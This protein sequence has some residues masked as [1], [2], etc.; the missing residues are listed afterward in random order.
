[1]SRVART[2]GPLVARAAVLALLALAAALAGCQSA[3]TVRAPPAATTAS[4]ATTPPGGPAPTGL[5]PEPGAALLHVDTAASRI[6]MRLAAAGALAALGHSHVV[7]AQGLA[8]E[9]LLPPEPAGTRFELSFPVAQLRVDDPADRAAAGGEFAAPIPDT[10]RAGTREHM[11]G[12]G[13]LDA[14]HFARIVLRGQS[15]RVLR[16]DAAAGEGELALVIELLGR[17]V[18]LTAPV[19]WQ[20]TA[21]GL[22]VQGELRLLQSALGIQPYSVGGGALRVADEVGVRYTLLAR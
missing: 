2:A 21:H 19:R 1:L 3:P 14:T 13:Q 16:G 11:L 8:G 12:P 18:P 17:S 4:P 7:V 22:E 5:L 9:V 15:L 20:R 10:A 6:E